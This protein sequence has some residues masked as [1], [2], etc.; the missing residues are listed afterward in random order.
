[1]LLA[2]GFRISTQLRWAGATGALQLRGGMPARGARWGRTGSRRLRR[3]AS[4]GRRGPPHAP[5]SSGW[6]RRRARRPLGGRGGGGCARR[7]AGDGGEGR[8]GGGS[9][10]AG[11]HAAGG[12]PAH[13]R[14]GRAVAGQRALSEELAWPGG[15]GRVVTQSAAWEGRGRHAQQREAPA[16]SAL[17]PAPPPHPF[18]HPQGSPHLSPGP[19]SAQSSRPA[20]SRRAP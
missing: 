13:R 20:A 12:P 18:Q 5:Q 17:A 15:S 11:Q 14:Q 19:P 8:T 10:R 6:S 9:V 3:R 7:L 2:Q 1:M 16:A 4:W